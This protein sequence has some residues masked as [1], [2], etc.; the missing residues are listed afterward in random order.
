MK[1]PDRRC[2]N[3]FHHSYDKQEHCW[4]CDSKTR[5]HDQDTRARLIRQGG[6]YPLASRPTLWLAPGE[7]DRFEAE[8][9]IAMYVVN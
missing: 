2:F 4:V 7:R 8:A 6:I 1:S 5:E 9:R 3:V